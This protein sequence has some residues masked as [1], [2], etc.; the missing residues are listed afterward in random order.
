MNWWRSKLFLFFALLPISSLWAQDNGYARAWMDTLASPTYSGRGYTYNGM[1]LAADALAREFARLGLESIGPD[2][3]QWF[4]LEVNVFDSV[5]LRIN[6]RTLTPGVHYLVHPESAAGEGQKLKAGK[7]FQLVG[8]K[9][10][11]SRLATQKPTRVL[12]EHGEQPLIWSVGRDVQRQ[13]RFVVHDSVLPVRVKRIDYVVRSRF[14]KQQQANVIGLLR[15]S[16]QPDSF[17]VICAHYDHL[18]TMGKSTLF[19]GAHDN[20]SGTALLLDLARHYSQPVNRPAYSILFIAFGAEEAGLVGSRYFVEEEPLVPLKRIR[21]VVNLD[22]LGGGSEG[23]TVVNATSHPKEFNWLS[24]RNAQR[25][26]LPKVVQRENSRN[27]DHY[28]FTTRKVPAF[29]VYT[30]GDVTAYHNIFDRP[31]DVPFKVYDQVFGLLLDFS[32]YLQGRE[33]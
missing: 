25:Y 16:S 6:G 10:A 27:S 12:L 15:G 8:R 5:L 13:S 33:H 2:Y 23:I 20:A 1:Q 19:P 24:E 3:R 22:L 31:E 14:E 26:Q 18:G 28:P 30:L 29:F 4:P 9:D 17:V 21:F 11:A 32:W 7:G